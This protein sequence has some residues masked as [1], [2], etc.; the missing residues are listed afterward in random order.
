MYTF[1]T[2]Y[3]ELLC[4]VAVAEPPKCLGPTTPVIVP[5]TCD[6]DVGD[7]PTLEVR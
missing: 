1:E 4:Y 6:S 5:R 2:E 7:P 3:Y